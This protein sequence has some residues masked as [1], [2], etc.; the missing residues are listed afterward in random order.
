MRISCDSPKIKICDALYNLL[1]DRF[2]NRIINNVDVSKQNC[3][4]VRWFRK[5]L[6]P[7]C[8]LVTLLGH[9]IEDIKCATADSTLLYHP[10][11]R[12]VPASGTTGDLEGCYLHYNSNLHCWVRSGLTVGSDSLPRR[13]MN[14]AQSQHILRSRTKA[15]NKRFELYYPDRTLDSITSIRRG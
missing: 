5:N 6:G 14:C 12:F 10:Q 2:N 4:T 8:S 11:D 1:H 9:V 13:S 7:F 15:S 3:L